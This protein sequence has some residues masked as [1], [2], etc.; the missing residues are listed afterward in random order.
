MGLIDSSILAAYRSLQVDGEPDFV[1]QLVQVFVDQ[2]HS[3]IEGLRVAVQQ[4]DREGVFRITHA[5][6]SSAA[7]L[8]ATDLASR[9]A[10]LERLA[11]QGAP[12]KAVARQLDV[13]V[14]AFE[15]ASKALTEA[16]DSP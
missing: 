2:G 11:E 1:A 14:R 10:Q 7:Q 4:G 3:R 5:L 15:A 13:V 8:G 6:K 16:A 9:S 12:M